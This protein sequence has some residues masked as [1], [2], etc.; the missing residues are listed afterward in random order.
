M[1]DKT[2]TIV[3]PIIQRVLAENELQAL[4]CADEEL[5]ELQLEYDNGKIVDV[6]DAKKA[7]QTNQI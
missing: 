5:A 3:R 1:T 4:K 6:I 7:K 2:F